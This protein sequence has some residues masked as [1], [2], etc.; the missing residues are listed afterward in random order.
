MS[1]MKFVAPEIPGYNYGSAEVAQ[2]PIT[3]RELEQLKQSA[4]FTKDDEQW[5]R[6]AGEVLADQTKAVV[7]K[8]RGIISAR[9]HLAKYS[10]RPDGQKIHTTRRPADYGFSSGFLILASVRMTRTGSIISRRWH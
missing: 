6:R 10:L 3:L 1:N 5:L 9:P 7:E 2:S 8:W 4:G